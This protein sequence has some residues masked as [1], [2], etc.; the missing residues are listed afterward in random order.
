[1]K[2]EVVWLEK[3]KQDFSNCILYLNENWGNKTANNFG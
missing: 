1:M 2:L 3:A